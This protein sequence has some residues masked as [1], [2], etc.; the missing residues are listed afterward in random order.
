M[1][2]VKEP[3]MRHFFQKTCGRPE[4][5]YYLEPADSI[6]NFTANTSLFALFLT[7]SVIREKPLRENQIESAC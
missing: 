7:V 3:L 2:G 6:K 4:H 1:S 5:L